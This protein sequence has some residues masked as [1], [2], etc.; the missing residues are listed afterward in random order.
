MCEQTSDVDSVVR[1]SEVKSDV[2][3]AVVSAVVRCSEQT[4]DVDSVVRCSEV[5]SDVNIAVVS[6]VVRCSKCCT[7]MLSVL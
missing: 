4:S 3:I 5:K 7:Q 6:A 2:N 1:C